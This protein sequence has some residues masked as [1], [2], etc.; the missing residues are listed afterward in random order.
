MPK[1]LVAQK[2]WIVAAI[3]AAITGVTVYALTDNKQSTT[4]PATELNSQAAVAGANS[5]QTATAVVAAENAQPAA[6]ITPAPAL[7]KELAN[8]QKLAKDGFA[9]QALENV[10]TLLLDHP[11]HYAALL[12]R[13]QLLLQLDRLDDADALLQQLIKDHPKRP[14]PLNN[15]AVLIAKRGN[16]KAAVDTLLKAFDTHPSYANVQKNLSELYATMASQAYSKALDLETEVIAPHLATLGNK[17]D[18]QSPGP[19]PFIAAKSVTE[20]VAELAAAQAENQVK[21]SPA[22]AESAAAAEKPAEQP[23]VTVSEREIIETLAKIEQQ[24]SE[25]TTEPS[26]DAGGAAGKQVIAE[27]ESDKRAS[28]NATKTQQ[29]TQDR[30]VAK[31][32][33]AA[34]PVNTSPDTEQDTAQGETAQPSVQEEEAQQPEQQQLAQA[35]PEPVQEV[36]AVAQ[37]AEKP[38]ETIASRKQAVE[39]KVRLWADAW[40]RQDVDGYIAAYAPEYRPNSA[41]SHSRWKR[42]RA[43]RLKKPSFINIELSELKVYLRSDKQAAVRF[44]Q[45]YSSD[46]YSDQTHKELELIKLENGWRIVKERSL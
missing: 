12:T 24:I 3:A 20:T 43:S 26:G 22:T 42:Q 6:E 46:N 10:D 17:G 9:K 11:A 29:A 28:D 16:Y 13:S 41:T 34:E 4:G 33:P 45:R 23:E 8:I 5:A 15:M 1:T 21:K 27:A 18:Q 32:Q 36:T 7:Q 37:T 44:M 2:T 40:Q 35:E 14:E 30:D 19:L 38:I 31:Q 25:D 39:Q